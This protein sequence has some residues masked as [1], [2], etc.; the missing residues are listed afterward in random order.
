MTVGLLSRAFQALGTPTR[1]REGPAHETWPCPA[2]DRRV[3][4][5]TTPAGLRPRGYWLPPSAAEL[6]AVCAVQHGAHRRDGSALPPS[7]PDDADRRWRVVEWGPGQAGHRP[8]LVLV[9]PAGVALVPDG[10]GA[11]EVVVVDRLEPSDLVGSWDRLLA[12]GEHTGTVPGNAV[13]LDPTS[14]LV[15]W[16]RLVAEGG[17]VLPPV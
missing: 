1:V 16:D 12:G 13:S 5:E 8:L 15:D 11:F 6:K 14:R 7:Q 3:E 17:G 2:C 10:T 9:P 4:I